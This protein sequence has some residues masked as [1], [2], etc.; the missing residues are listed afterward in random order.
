MTKDP[1]RRDLE[2]LTGEQPR[3]EDW[4]AG[5]RRRVSQRRARTAGAAA[6]SL[7]AVLGIGVAIR[8]TGPTATP[9]D[10]ASAIPVVTDGSTPESTAEA[11]A[12]ADEASLGP[13]AGPPSRTP[14]ERTEN[15]S[16][17][18][19]IASHIELTPTNPVAGEP[20]TARLVRDDGDA[21]ELFVDY[22]TAGNIGWIR[23]LPHFVTSSCI[24]DPLNSCHDLERWTWGADCVGFDTLES[25]TDDLQWVFHAPGEYVIDMRGIDLRSELWNE[26][27]VAHSSLRVTV[28]PN[29][30]ATP[31]PTTGSSAEPTRSP[32]DAATADPTSDS[33]GTPAPE[34]T[35]T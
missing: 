21:H 8:H 11:S 3:V 35:P 34:P 13:S 33:T 25:R 15:P 23:C 12:G 26:I 28:A 24:M 7:V 31:D 17:N 4:H 1:L 14:E 19:A 16:G 32:T 27:P 30:T 2:A 20:V 22:F 6:L 18:L 29:P 5:I 10:S 9:V